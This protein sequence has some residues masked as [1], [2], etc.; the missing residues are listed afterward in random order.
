M[1]FT[2]PPTMTNGVSDFTK[3]D[4]NTYLR[5]N[6]ASTRDRGA[7][8]VD[9]AP[10]SA[11]TGVTLPHDL[12]TEEFDTG[13][14]YSAG[15]DHFDLFTDADD[16]VWYVGS[17]GKWTNESSSGDRQ[18]VIQDST[19][20]TP[21]DTLTV[22]RFSAPGQVA[23]GTVATVYQFDTA[24]RD[25]MSSLVQDSGSTLTQTGTQ[26][27]A[28]VGSSVRPSIIGNPFRNAL[29]LGQ[30]TGATVWWN[31]VVRDCMLRVRSRPMARVYRT[32]T[33]T[34]ADGV[35]TTFPF[36]TA[37]S[38][39]IGL[40]SA[41]DR[42]RFTVPADHGGLYFVAGCVGVSGVSSA[43]S[44]LRARFQING[45][46]TR[47]QQ[48]VRNSS[49]ST[50]YVPINGVL[51]LEG[52][53]EVTLQVRQD[54]GASRSSVAGVQTH[55]AIFAL[56]ITDQTV[57]DRQYFT[58]GVLP[59]EIDFTDMS[60]A[61][62][63][64]GTLNVYARDTLLHLWNPP[65]IGGFAETDEETIGAGAWQD[66]GCGLQLF[67]AWGEST[68]PA[69]S[70]LGSNRLTLP[71]DGLWLLVAQVDM[72]AQGVGD[73]G[74]RG[75]KIRHGGYHESPVRVASMTAATHSWQC[76]TSAIVNGRAGEEVWVQALQNRADGDD[77]TI[78]NAA[79][80]AAWLR[81]YIP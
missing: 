3:A 29:T 72:N 6:L 15:A 70:W 79:I 19:T 18:I 61:Y 24:D 77:L 38:D 66:V 9:A 57:T 33:T 4:L 78:E 62:A 46:S 41:A 74:N 65:V 31:N 30:T 23:R 27:A 52:G 81:P 60:G 55:M 75:L 35:W 50:Q 26:W 5:D 13:G 1:A 12:F 53:D 45:V 40:T 69:S 28:L 36:T 21:N 80:V 58:D 48:S 71:H 63:Y 73:E 43:G 2:A 54:S 47:W 44:R 8:K 51:Q 25:A 59:P 20:T 76:T 34:L 32:S 67:N 10:D 42:S 11:A 17:T 56:S 37:V 64:P 68:M 7:V 49:A 16:T 39:N 14:K 22:G